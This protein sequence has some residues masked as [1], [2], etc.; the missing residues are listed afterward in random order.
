MSTLKVCI[1][2]VITNLVSGDKIITPGAIVQLVFTTRLA[3]EDDYKTSIKPEVTDTS[4]TDDSDIEEDDVE[5][6]I[7]R[8]KANLDGDSVVIPLA[9]APYFPLVFLSRRRV[10][11]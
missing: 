7:N 6:L 4:S 10:D 5:F 3:T 11:L 8:K 9:H 1:P 2:G